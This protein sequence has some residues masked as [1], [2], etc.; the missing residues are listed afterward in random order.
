MIS[1][2]VATELKGSVRGDVI[3]PNDGRYVR[4]KY[5]SE[6]LFR[7]NQNISPA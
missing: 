1:E 2:K 3:L 5:D 6:N 4:A 7:Y